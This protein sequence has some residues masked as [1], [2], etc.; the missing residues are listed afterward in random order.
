[1]KLVLSFNIHSVSRSDK[2]CL[3][4]GLVEGFQ[5]GI[6]GSAGKVVR[7]GYSIIKQPFS[8]G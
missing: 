1:M 4:T 6:E 2:T 7:V 5:D 3:L 8:F